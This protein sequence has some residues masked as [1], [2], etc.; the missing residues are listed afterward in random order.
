MPLILTDENFEKEISQATKP[1]LVDFW[2]EGCGPCQLIA[3]ILEQIAKEMAEQIIFAKVNF[4]DALA[5]LQRYDIVAAPTVI[6]F[7]KG[8]PVSGF[9]GLQPAEMIRKWLVDSLK[10]D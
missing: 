10:N 2:L 9:V 4:K 8:Q 3:P 6:L 7:K 5:T 1:V